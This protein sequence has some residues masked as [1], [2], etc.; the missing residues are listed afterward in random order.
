M[1]D[2]P[3]AGQPHTLSVAIDASGNALALW[4][5]L[6]DREHAEILANRFAVGAG[7]S[8]PTKLSPT[9]TTGQATSPNVAIDDT[10]NAIA[11]WTSPSNGIEASRY[12]V[13]NGW[14]TP[15]EIHPNHAF[16]DRNPRVALDSVGNAVAVWWQPGPRHD[17]DALA[18]RYSAKDGWGTAT[19]IEDDDTT[20]VNRVDVMFDKDGKAVAYWNS[21]IAPYHAYLNRESVGSWSKVARLP[22]NATATVG[23]EGRLVFVYK[24]S[25]GTKV[26][27][28]E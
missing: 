5:S 14:Q 12:V 23:A 25:D 1:I 4:D 6:V 21:V 20:S 18:V 2:N 27:R 10:G 11:V 15:V 24:A 3:S 26:A 16:E 28:L 8:T 22:G 9:G 17:G 13:G 7:W 19:L